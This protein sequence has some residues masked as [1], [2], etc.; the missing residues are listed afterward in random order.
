MY[1]KPPPS[2]QFGKKRSWLEKKI[3]AGPEKS[4]PLK[5]PEL[6]TTVKG[7]QDLYTKVFGVAPPR[8]QFG[9]KKAWLRKKISSMQK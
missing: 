8:N 6:P 4:V 2:N 3:R 5:T 9:N 1:G 7:L